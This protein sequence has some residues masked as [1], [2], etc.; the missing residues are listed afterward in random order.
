MRRVCR[1]LLLFILPIIVG[2]TLGMANNSYPPAFDMN[3]YNGVLEAYK[4]ASVLPETAPKIVGSPEIH[5][6]AETVIFEDGFE[7]GG[8]NWTVDENTPWEFG[9]PTNEYGPESAYGGTNVAAVGLSA[10][11]PV[12]TTSG[13]LVSQEIA[14]SDGYD[15]IRMEF[16]LWYKLY[17]DNFYVEISTDSG[18]TWTSI[19]PLDV[20][21]YGYL[22]YDYEGATYQSTTRGSWNNIVCDLTDYKGSNILIRFRIYAGYG[23]YNNEPGLF[24]DNVKVAGYDQ[25]DPLVA[26][27]PT[28]YTWPGEEATLWG[29]V[30]PDNDIGSYINSSYR[31]DFG[32]G[33]DPVTGI[34]TDPNY[35]VEKHTYSTAGTKTATLT[36]DPTGT[37]NFASGISQTVRINV[38]VDNLE[39]R[40]LKAIE[41]GLRWL[42][43][44]ARTNGRIGSDTYWVGETGLAILA[45]EEQGHH[46]GSSITTDIYS[47]IVKKGLEAIIGNAKKYVFA[48]RTAPA[49]PG[50]PDTNGNGYGYYL[51]VDASATKYTTGVCMLTIIASRTPDEVITSGAAAGDTYR[52]LIQDI[53]DYYAFVQSDTTS[54]SARGG[55]RYNVDHS[56]DSDNSAAQWPALGMMAAEQEWGCTVPSWVK[57]ELRYWLDYSQADNGGYT[58]TGPGNSVGMTGAALCQWA[59]VGENAS[60]EQ[61]ALSLDF[62]NEFWDY[63]DGRYGHLNGNYYSLYAVAKGCRVMRYPDGSQVNLIGQTHNWWNEYVDH[64][65]NDE[66]YKQGIESDDPAYDGKWRYGYWNGGGY[67]FNVM[68][69]RIL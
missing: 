56:S 21:P 61:V 58:Y 9:A 5:K 33:S 36:I 14:L 59:F 11:Y 6:P 69:K 57:S 55:W 27:M 40:R 3:E 65:V 7:S 10:V 66:T 60:S 44:Q 19:L 31:W 12:N 46:A 18:S 25:G 63:R 24:I 2:T 16:K 67:S 29:S 52:E 50:N 37:N 68:Y 15:V 23:S 39:T 45:F 34:V 20:F 4:A 51:G 43:T 32:D 17:Y 47:P 8:G 53:C 22:Y 38:A 13:G 35:I 1:Y 49:H 64:L 48:D 41:D 62:L 30:T 42:Y 28:Y 26:V 54:W